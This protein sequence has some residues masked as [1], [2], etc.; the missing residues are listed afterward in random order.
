MFNNG[1]RA[2]RVDGPNT[3]PSKPDADAEETARLG[4]ASG[5]S[6]A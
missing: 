2:S 5:R 3:R 6:L 1:K 4:F